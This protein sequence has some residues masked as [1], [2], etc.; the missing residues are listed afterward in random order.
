MG[1]RKSSAIAKEKR[2][3]TAGL[4]MFLERASRLERAWISGLRQCLVGGGLFGIGDFLDELPGARE[5][6]VERLMYSLYLEGIVG[7][8]GFQWY[9]REKLG[10]LIRSSGAPGHPAALIAWVAA[11]SGLVGRREWMAFGARV[12]NH[13]I[14]DALAT[15]Y[16]KSWSR[17]LQSAT[18]GRWQNSF[19]GYLAG[20][21]ESGEELL[22]Q[23]QWAAIGHPFHPLA[24]AKVD[25]KPAE[26]LDY[27]P[28]FRNRVGL[29]WLALHKDRAQVELCEGIDDYSDWVSD[30]YPQVMH[31]WRTELRAQGCE[32]E[33]FVPLPAH[34][35][36]IANRIRKRF[37]GLIADQRI[38]LLGNAISSYSPLMSFRT[39]SSASDPRQP[40]IKLPIDILLTS[41]HRT[42]SPRTCEMSPRIGAMLR[43]LFETVPALS[44]HLRL[45][46]EICG[47]HYQDARGAQAEK[48]LAAVF[49]Q[50]LAAVRRPGE[51]FVPCA[52]L[53]ADSPF[54]GKPLILELIER[55]CGA[56]SQEGV[57]R[58]FADYVQRL[59]PGLLRLYL[60]YG[61]ALEAHHQN[62]LLVLDRG[63][64]IN[65]FVLRDLGGIRLH[66]PSVKSAGLFLQLHEDRL[67]V[68][69]DREPVRHKFVAAV[70]FFHLGQLVA[71]L[72]RTTGTP[73]ELMWRELLIGLK[74]SLNELK[75]EVPA[76][77]WAEERQAFLENDWQAKPLM[78]MNLDAGLADPYIPVG[79][80]L[81]DLK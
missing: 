79:N 29:Q 23:E 44:A 7:S 28:D 49:R 67:T 12:A 2:D 8:P 22:F 17:I 71:H 47:V 57:R 6:A 10:D 34:P 39:L 62:T 31:R 45:Q 69:H 32:P 21:A 41:V 48:Q 18:A 11:Q 14:N 38:V 4:S 59:L 61:I 63:H 77:L 35:W 43:Q 64:R 52:A 26:V 66:W 24:K 40:D 68:C 36:Q 46:P 70:M 16:R 53:L 60:V 19:L 25:L 5:R 80:P 9:R 42:I 13:Y 37:A 15:G 58:F 73:S 30:L 78:R 50:P 65:G 1:N 51:Y 72:Q 27:A 56:V 54:G 3:F 76:E 55:R 81:Q 74:S 33:A 20:L 75:P